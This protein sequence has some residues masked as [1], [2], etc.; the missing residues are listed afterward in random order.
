MKIKARNGWKR[1]RARVGAALVLGVMGALPAAAGAEG[2][3][4]GYD[5]AHD[6]GSLLTTAQEV[7]GAGEMWNDGYTGRGVDVAVLDTGVA[8]VNGLSG[9][10]VIHGPDLSF[11]SQADNLRHLDT[12]GHGT[13]MAGIIAGRE[14]GVTTIQKGDERFLGVAPD[15]RIVS[16][17]LGDAAGATDV[18]QVVAAIHW[19]VQNRRANGLNIRVLNLSYGTDAEQLWTADPLAHAVDIAWRKGIVVVVSA[20]NGGYGSAKLNNPALNPRVIAV[21]AVDGKGT[22]TAQDDDI[23]AWSSSG[24]AARR[25]DL[26][27]PGRSIAS[28]RVPGSAVDVAHPEGRTAAAGVFRGSGSSLAAAVVSGAAALVLSQRPSLTPDQVK[29]LL[30]QTAAPLPGVD[31]TRQGA[32]L[33][34]L[35]VARDTPT[36]EDGQ[37]L[38]IATGNGSLERARGTAHLSSDGVEL[39]GEQDIFGA[40]WISA[41]LAAAGEAGVSWTDGR[42]NGTAWTGAALSGNVWS[43]VSW[44]RS[45]WSGLAWTRSSWSGNA[46]TR[47][48]WSGGSWTRSSWSGG[49]WTRSSW[50][51][52]GWGTETVS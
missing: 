32:G 30:V 31:P 49:T 4:S 14:D 39:R 33:I 22:Y 43:G 25:P 18:S 40:P 28:L 23:P 35:K 8:P 50:S 2:E 11:E 10:K 26:V 13:H 5:A 38:P 19:V 7:I 16:L 46:W 1:S 20:G 42:F 27:A 37:S 36:P 6:P 21:G 3:F 17:K 9:D 15:A 24:D 48:S 52:A 45:S 41:T 29:A 12:Y 47:S 44:T 34:D 51:G